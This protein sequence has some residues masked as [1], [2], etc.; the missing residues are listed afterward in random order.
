MKLAYEQKVEIYR[1]LKEEYCTWSSLSKKWEIN[2]ESLVYMVSLI[3]RHGIDVTGKI[4][5]T[6][7]CK[8]NS[9]ILVTF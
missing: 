1:E 5:V 7:L 9:P 4:K 6:N 3:D 8:Q 2:I